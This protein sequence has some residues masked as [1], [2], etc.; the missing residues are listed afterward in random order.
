MDSFEMLSSLGKDLTILYVEDE[1][2][3]QKTV[4]NTL[5]Y[6]FKE[7]KTADNGEEA[8]KIFV[9]HTPD[10]VISDIRMPKKTGLELL[11]EIKELSPQQRVVITSAYG[12]ELALYKMI[13]L[14]VDAFM[15][16]PL[17]QDKFMKTLIDTAILIKED[18]VEKF[19]KKKLEEKNGELS[20]VV[21]IL[22][23][24]LK[25]LAMP[26]ILKRKEQ[27]KRNKQ[28]ALNKEDNY[29][30]L[31]KEDLDE[32][33]EL[34]SDIDYLISKV[35]LNQK[36]S[37]IELEHLSE[38]LKRYASVLVQY[39]SLTTLGEHIHNLSEAIKENTDVS[40]E[41]MISA[42]TF[43]ESFIYVLG[44]WRVDTIEDNSVDKMIYENSLISDIAQIISSLEGNEDDIDNEI[45]FF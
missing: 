15:S 37:P 41:R 5:R 14:G 27:K 17:D 36:Y 34:E 31:I 44:K 4:A 2:E 3:L 6:F 18:S 43:A 19:Y 25:Q 8:I 35:V 26:S 1:L 33:K 9:D 7:V 21:K 38:K 12:D 40:K 23:N 39:Y 20:K 24:K 22:K 29:E 10:I 11:K 13:D 42:F 16:K 45:E 28:L 32:I 30:N